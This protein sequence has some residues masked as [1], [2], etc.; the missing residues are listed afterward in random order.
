[1]CCFY[2]VDETNEVR[3]MNEIEVNLS[4]E[5]I[6]VINDAYRDDLQYWEK[7]AFDSVLT[8]NERKDLT[9]LAPPYFSGIS[10]FN[11]Q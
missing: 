9:D 1:M 3:T 10:V 8:E 4:Q 6:K 7:V 2:Y 5:K 11:S